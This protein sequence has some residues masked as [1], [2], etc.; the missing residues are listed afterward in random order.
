MNPDKHFDRLM[1]GAGIVAAVLLVVLAGTA[2]GAAIAMGIK[3]VEPVSKYVGQTLAVVVVFY[4]L[5]YG[6]ELATDEP[7]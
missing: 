1:W 4:V 3:L 5:G 6:V 2:I 7:P